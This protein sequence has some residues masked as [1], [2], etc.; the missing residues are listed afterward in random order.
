M[1]D[2]N[3][4]SQIP[5]DRDDDE[6]RIW[7]EEERAMRELLASL[8]PPPPLEDLARAQGVRIPQRWEDLLPDWSEDECDEEEDF[9]PVR[10]RWREEQIALEQERYA[11]LFPEDDAT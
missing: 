8:P 5:T 6:K 10:R 2:M 11:R 9:D 1:V 3:A 7:A 4:V